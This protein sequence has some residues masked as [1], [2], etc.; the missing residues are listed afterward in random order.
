MKQET[1]LLNMHLLC[2]DQMCI[3]LLFLHTS[4]QLPE[5]QTKFILTSTKKLYAHHPSN[6]AYLTR[7][8]IYD[9]NKKKLQLILILMNSIIILLIF[10]NNLSYQNLK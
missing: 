2:D 7:T 1:C 4:V 9:F 3:P 10:I 8:V 5:I 6:I